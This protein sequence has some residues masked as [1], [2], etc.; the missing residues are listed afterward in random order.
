[1]LL[2]KTKSVFNYTLVSIKC[3]TTPFKCKTVEDDNVNTSGLHMS[4]AMFTKGIPFCL[5]EKVS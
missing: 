1:M 2:L 4:S 5:L 3:A